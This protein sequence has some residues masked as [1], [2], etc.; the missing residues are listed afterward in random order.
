MLLFCAMT[1]TGMGQTGSFRIAGRVVSAVDGHPLERAA[2]AIEA[3]KSR[4]RVA[5]M[6]SGA[7]GEFAFE[8]LAAG[9]YTLF[10]DAPGYVAAN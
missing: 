2:V 10:A 4:A 5:T 7:A 9:K 3:V 8:H 6:V 1:L